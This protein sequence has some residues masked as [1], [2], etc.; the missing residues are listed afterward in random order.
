MLRQFYGLATRI[1]G[2]EDNPVWHCMEDLQDAAMTMAP[3]T[4]EGCAA[5][6]AIA[7]IDVDDVGD[8]DPPLNRMERDAIFAARDILLSGTPKQ[9]TTTQ[10]ENHGTD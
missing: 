9:P 4:L 6:V 3:S 2:D 10:G 5:K 7:N 1:L 8:D